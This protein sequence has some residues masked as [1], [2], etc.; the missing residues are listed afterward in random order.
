M[1]ISA[2]GHALA[3]MWQ[4]DQDKF[5]KV[6]LDRHKN[7]T[8]FWSSD[9][10]AALVRRHP[11]LSGRSAAELASTLPIGFHGDGGAMSHQDSLYV[12]SW[13][14][15]LGIGNTADKRFIFTVTIFR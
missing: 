2:P 9:E 3:K 6:F 11:V 7:C 14:S 8:P 13:N 12:A 5:R 1:P 15:L 4:A 10:G